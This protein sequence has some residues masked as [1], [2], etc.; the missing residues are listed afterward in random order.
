M[1]PVG[2]PFLQFINPYV[3][4]CLHK[5]F[6][7]LQLGLWN[8]IPM[9]FYGMLQKYLP[10]FRAIDELGHQSTTN[11]PGGRLAN[12]TYV[13]TTEV[14]ARHGNRV[15]NLGGSVK[16][17]LFSTR[18]GEM[19]HFDDVF[20]LGWNHQ[21]VNDSISVFW[22]T[23]RISWVPFSGRGEAVFFAGV[24]RSPKWRQLAFWK[25]RNKKLDRLCQGGFNS[26]PFFIS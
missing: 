25:G 15:V 16:H 10:G 13:S 9:K 6:Q 2:F 19:I 22:G 23:L 11:V 18:L 21:L 24:F 12:A 4:Q 8:F 7:E 14:R 20:K 5:P 26:R 3:F 17:L 1:D